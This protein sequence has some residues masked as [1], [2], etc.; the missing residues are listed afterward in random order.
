V[1]F[2][3]HGAKGVELNMWYMFMNASIQGTARRVKAMSNYQVQQIVGWVVASGFLLDIL[4]R[5][6]AGDDN[7]D[8]END[9][10]QLP[11][12]IKAMNFVFGSAIVR[13]RCQCPTGIT[14]SPMSG[15]R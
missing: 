3:R 8:G 10:D 11:E 6:L 1:N 5:S 7:D 15:A 9:Y 2:N 12:H 14:S 4:A 13:S